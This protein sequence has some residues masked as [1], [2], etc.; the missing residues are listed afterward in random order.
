MKNKNKFLAY[1]YTDNYYF[2]LSESYHKQPFRG[3]GNG[4]EM[5]HCMHIQIK[6]KNK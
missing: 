5:T 6:G 2:V 1:N 4:G 3:G